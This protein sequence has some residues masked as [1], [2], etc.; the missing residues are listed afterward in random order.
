MLKRRWNQRPQRTG[1]HI[2][3]DGG[4]EVGNR[5]HGE[6]GIEDHGL[7]RRGSGLQGRESEVIKTRGGEIKWDGGEY[8]H[9]GI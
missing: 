3:E 4:L 7:N 1:G 9:G 5:N 2:T 8:R 6:G